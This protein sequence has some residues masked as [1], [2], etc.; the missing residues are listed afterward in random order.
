MCHSTHSTLS[1]AAGKIAKQLHSSP[2]STRLNTAGDI[3]HWDQKLWGGLPKTKWYFSNICSHCNRDKQTSSWKFFFYAYH[4]GGGGCDT[5]IF[6]ADNDV[7]NNLA[8]KCQWMRSNTLLVQC[9]ST[10]KILVSSSVRLV[11]WGIPNITRIYWYFLLKCSF[12]GCL[13]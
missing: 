1:Y 10:R 5:F 13:G 12:L 8:D 6:L 2:N 7:N 9:Q 11:N 4:L 3:W